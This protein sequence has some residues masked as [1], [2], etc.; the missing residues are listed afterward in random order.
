MSI[1]EDGERKQVRM[2]HLA[3][4]GSHSVNGVAA[5]HSELVKTTLGAGLL[6]TVARKIQQQN[7]RRNPT[8]LVAEGQPT[9]C[10]FDNRTIGDTWITELDDVRELEKYADVEGNSRRVP[11]DQ[12]REQRATGKGHQ[13]YD[14]HG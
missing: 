7:Q 13:S 14:T 4:V 2:A 5:L 9:A 3:I 1:I 12:T 8:P 6:S 11:Q 10:K